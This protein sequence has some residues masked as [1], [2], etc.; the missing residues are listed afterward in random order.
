L[1]STS[2]AIM[3]NTYTSPVNVTGKC[4]ITESILIW[5]PIIWFKLKS[6]GMNQYPVIIYLLLL[7]CHTWFKENTII[8]AFSYII[9]RLNI[10][11]ILHE[12]F[13]RTRTK[14]IY[15][16][17]F[18]VPNYS[19]LQY[20]WLGGY[21]PQ[22]PI[23]S[24]LCPQLNLLNPPP[25]KI[26]GYATDNHNALLCPALVFMKQNGSMEGIRAGLKMV[27]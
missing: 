20:P 2:R 10:R 9:C 22:N 8:T 18:L 24:V 11:F 15:E 5:S 23:L 6:A 4:Q 3:N 12:L 13:F 21:H 14:N 25:N 1:T 27:I 19:C 7:L 16:M 26:P 17:K